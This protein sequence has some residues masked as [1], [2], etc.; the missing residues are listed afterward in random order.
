MGIDKALKID[1]WM[2]EAELT[3][4]AMQARRHMRIVEIGSYKG[5]STVAL[6]GNTHGLVVAVDDFYGPREIE[7]AG[8][9]SIYDQY[10]KNTAGL[11]N[12]HTIRCNHH[13]LPDPGF[14]PDMVFID[15][16]HEY[17]NVAADVLYWLPRMAKGGLLSGHDYGWADGVTK[18][19]EELVPG[20]SVAPGG[21]IWYATV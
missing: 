12:L 8:R 1:G 11:A 17:E 6:A 21:S 18:A 19:V 13:D 3:W 2:N 7:L 16:G 5:R 9:D 15:G 20:F 4:L 14:A 10:L